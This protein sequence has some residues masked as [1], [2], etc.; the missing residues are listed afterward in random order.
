MVDASCPLAESPVHLSN[1]L[2]NKEKIWG[3]SSNTRKEQNAD[4]LLQEPA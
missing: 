4:D 2:S 3:C 1:H